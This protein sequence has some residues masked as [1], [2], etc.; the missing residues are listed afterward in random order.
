MRKLKKELMS[1]RVK[2]KD[3][4]PQDDISI[5]CTLLV[6]IARKKSTLAVNV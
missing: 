4:K 1:Q 2:L 5:S 6:Y 3:L